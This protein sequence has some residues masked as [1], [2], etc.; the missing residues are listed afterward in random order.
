MSSDLKALRDRIDSTDEKII[1]LIKKRMEIVKEIA[2]IK[3]EKGLPILDPE[4][5]EDLYRRIRREAE[6]LGLDGSDT[7]TI[8]REIVSVSRKLQGEERIVA[9]LGPRG[10]FTEEAARK[11][12]PTTG[13]QF[14]PCTSIFDTFRSVS[15]GGAQYGVV[16]VENSTEGS[17]NTTLDLLLES[18]LMLWGEIDLPISHNLLC[19]PGTDL[20]EIRIIIS[21]PQALA[22]CRRYLE[23]HFPAVEL[24]EASSTGSAVELAKDLNNA[25]AIGTSLAAKIYGMEIAAEAIQDNSLNYTRFLVL[26]KNDRK[27][28]GNDKTSIVFSVKHVPGALYSALQVFAENNINMTKI[29]SRPTKQK[30]WEYVFFIDFEGHRNSKIVSEALDN[31]RDRTLFLKILGS[32]PRWSS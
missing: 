8:F 11:L 29:E 2:K 1:Y 30:Q 22:Q 10:T 32:Y 18:D 9:F 27:P 6:K 20:D 19:R 25:A 24:R 3:R 26:S 15:S 7:E 16:P 14:I 31:L 23:E 21:H 12:F 4:R 17:V 13:T 28:T 5:E